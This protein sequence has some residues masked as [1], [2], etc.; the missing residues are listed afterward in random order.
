MNRQYQFYNEQPRDVTRPHR[1][2]EKLADDEL[3]AA[4]WRELERSYSPTS[5]RVCIRTD[6]PRTMTDG[7]IILPEYHQGIAGGLPKGKT[8]WGTVL[9]VGPDVHLLKP[10]DRVA[11]PRGSWMW[12]HKMNDDTLVGLI[13]ESCIHLSAA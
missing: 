7:G 3:I 2:E 12:L 11:Y 4:T 8:V 9:A 10:G 5:E 13:K 6:P 1:D